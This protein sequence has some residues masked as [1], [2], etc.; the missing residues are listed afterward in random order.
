MRFSLRNYSSR[1]W[2]NPILSL[3]SILL[4]IL[5]FE[6]VFRIYFKQPLFRLK[7]YRVRT[8]DLYRLAL[9]TQFDSL[10]GWIPKPG[11]SGNQ[12][13]WGTQV[14]ILDDG[15][16]ANDNGDLKLNDPLPVLV[17]GD[18]FT[19]GDQVSN[20]ETWPSILER[21]IRKPV[22]NA[23]V[24]AYGID[25]IF[26]RL[27][28]LIPRYK[29][30]TIIFSFTPL[31]I[32]RCAH[33]VFMGGNKPYFIIQNNSLIL[34]N[35]PVE[36]K[37]IKPAKI[38]GVLGYS[39]FIHTIML[40]LAPVWW[41]QED[42]Y[43]ERNENFKEGKCKEVACLLFKELGF[44]IEDYN[45]KHAYILV[46]DISFPTKFHRDVDYILKCVDTSRVE[47]VDLRR[48]LYMI[49]IREPLRYKSFFD[50]HMTY[51]GNYFVAEK[52]FEVM[53]DDMETY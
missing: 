9:P 14:T 53:K 10:L 46:Q 12:N 24:F 49:K 26:L 13:M 28:Q 41:L 3:L 43:Y 7:D 17:V 27:R 42:E 50:G 48:H 6:C 18:S 38:R 16:R 5:F 51:K 52:L 11:F 33:S 47:V 34:K 21:F 40:K 31:D 4:I 30:D 1:W 36:K 29:P 37:Q 25:Q 23:G 2:I 32:E 35:V 8:R 22:L 44:L 19:F 20:N 45:I 39:F 15:I